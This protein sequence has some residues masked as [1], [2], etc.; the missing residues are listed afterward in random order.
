M[1]EKIFI[2]YNHHDKIIID[3]IARRLEIEFGRNNIFYDAWSMQPG[4]SIIGK[5]NLG[6][7]E[8]TTFFFFV[9]PKSLESNMVKLEWQTALNRAVNNNLKFVAVRVADC[10]MP[11][12]LTDKLYIDLYGEGLDTAVEKMRCVIKGENTYAP[13]EDVQNIQAVITQLD[14]HN[15]D[16]LIKAAYFVVHNPTVA[17]GLTAPKEQFMVTQVSEGMVISSEDIITTSNG[18]E[19]HA[20]RFGLCRALVPGQPFKVKLKLCENIAPFTIGFFIVQERNDAGYYI[21]RD[22]P[23]NK[24]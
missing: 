6:L 21:Y 9:S 3:T 8:F 13:L 10:S 18:Q 5:M 7:S 11:A 4:D 23:C 20:A 17:I 2:S 19:F 14:A 24:A 15:F 16:I 12:I 22:I 1:A